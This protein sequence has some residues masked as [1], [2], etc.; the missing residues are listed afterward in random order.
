[1]E[2]PSAPA[3]PDPVATANA[4]AD[5]N[6]K[7]AVA[8]QGLNSTDQITP[9][10]SLTYTQIGKWEDGTPHFQ[11]TTALSPEAQKIFDVNQGTK[12]NIATIGKDQSARIGDLLGTPLKLGNEEVEGRL[13]DLGMKRL[14]PQ[15]DRNEE[16]LRTRLVNA[17]IKEGSDAW[18][19]EMGRLTQSQNDAVDQ[20]ILSGR[21]TAN[22]E[23]MT[24]RNQP[25]NEITA[26]MSGS[27]VSNPSFTTT[28]QSQV[29]GVDYAGLVQQ[30]YANQVQQQQMQ[31]SNNQALMGGLFG[32]AG[33]GIGAGGR[34][35]QGKFA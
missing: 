26:L 5:M 15:F 1:M 12:L 10:G 27:Q 20:L 11:A 35:W 32:L 34:L 17:G 14:Q 4:Q 29:A 31:N 21:N 30:N 23:L 2:T 6:L 18:N 9:D 28:P 33:A 19:A 25:I 8:Q 7:T 16:A 22:Q 3:A 13:M 24:E